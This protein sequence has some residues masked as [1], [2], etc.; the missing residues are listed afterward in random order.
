[1]SLNTRLQ[2]GRNTDPDLDDIPG[3]LLQNAAHASRLR[4]RGAIRSGGRVDLFSSS[5]HPLGRDNPDCVLLSALRGA[6]D[7]RGV[8]WVICGGPEGDTSDSEDGDD[9]ENSL[10]S[11]SV[12]SFSS[13]PSPLPSVIDLRPSRARS[14]GRPP[15]LRKLAGRYRNGNGCGAV[16]HYYALSV[17]R[18]RSCAALV[19]PDDDDAAVGALPENTYPVP[20]SKAICQCARERVGCLRW[21]VPCDAPALVC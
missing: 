12:E 13:R 14:L 21:C 10:A 8:R 19:D 18:M 1:M 5:S 11:P 16:L 6:N 9:V 2:R 17:P 4:R 3:E 15:P 20:R 7:R